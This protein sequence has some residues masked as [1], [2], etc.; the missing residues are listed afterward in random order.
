MAEGARGAQLKER[1]KV[2][3]KEQEVPVVLVERE[4]EGPVD[5]EPESSKNQGARGAQLM[6]RKKKDTDPLEERQRKQREQAEQDRQQKE[7]EKEEAERVRLEDERKQKEEK[8]RQEQT[9]KQQEEDERKKK[10]LRKEKAERKKQE[11]QAKLVPVK[12]ENDDLP[13]Q[14]DFIVIAD[15]EEERDK[16]IEAAAGELPLV[17]VSL[18]K[19]ITELLNE[20]AIKSDLV[21]QWQEK[22]K[23]FEN[24]ANN[25]DLVV[26]DK[27]GL[28]SGLEE[29]V[30]NATGIN[31]ALREKLAQQKTEIEK[32][33]KAIEVKESSRR[34]LETRLEKAESDAKRETGANALL[35][36]QNEKLQNDN[37]SLRVTLRSIQSGGEAKQGFYQSEPLSLDSNVMHQQLGAALNKM[38]FKGRHNMEIRANDSVITIPH[39]HM[40]SNP[41]TREQCYAVRF[42][43][44]TQR[45]YEGSSLRKD[46][47]YSYGHMQVL[48]RDNQGVVVEDA[49]FDYSVNIQ[50]GQRTYLINA[51]RVN[52]YMNDIGEGTFR[53]KTIVINAM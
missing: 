10:Q 42:D 35:R 11:E 30:A 46:T 29:R 51:G 36:E 50:E 21:K 23:S 44:N 41:L 8:A 34:D 33:T 40:T 1:K 48:L 12:K 45:R 17:A 28:I 7:K 20:L 31:T 15:D 47:L 18:S 32:N 26:A 6:E 43:K 22:A 27:E 53:L 24:V 37:K 38:S 4:K 52:V 49:H 2:V 5:T 25:L 9:R 16:Q 3:E 19:R 39:V 14:P 13:R